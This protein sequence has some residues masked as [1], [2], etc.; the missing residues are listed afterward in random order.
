MRKKYFFI[1][2]VIIVAIAAWIFYL[3][4][5]RRPSLENMKADVTIKS[6]D[7][8]N[9]YRQNET[10]TNSK[11]LD[12]IIEVKGIVTDIQQTDSTLS[13]ELEGADSGGIN[14]GIADITHEEKLLFRKGS[15]LTVKGKCSGFLMDVNLVDCIIEK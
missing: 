9:Q 8:Y 13:I 14:C 12:K 6:T 4:M 5:E 7:L 10:S 1:G 3:F 2:G 11:Y 15:A